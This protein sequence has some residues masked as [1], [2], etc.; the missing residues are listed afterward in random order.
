ME[1]IIHFTTKNK[2]CSLNMELAL[3]IPLNSILTRKSERERQIPYA[4]TYMW[5]LKYDTDEF[6]YE[7]EIESENRQVAARGKKMGEGWTGSLRLADANW[8]IWICQVAFPHDSK[9]I[10]SFPGANW[11]CGIWIPN[12]GLITQPLYESF[13]RWDDSIPLM[14]GSPQKETET[15]LKQSITQA[16]ALRLPDPEKAFQLYVH[17]KEGIALGVLTQRLRPVPQSVSY[18]SNRLDP[19]ARG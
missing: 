8:Y 18:L 5:K 12:Y 7:T 2:I 6:I 9:T 14:R 17:E 11:V 16:F 4:I 1:P 10:V 19:T 3:V 15:T 13:K